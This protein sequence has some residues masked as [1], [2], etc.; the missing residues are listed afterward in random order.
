MCQN[1]TDWESLLSLYN[2]LNILSLCR[3]RFQ[4]NRKFAVFDPIFERSES[5]FGCSVSVFSVSKGIF[6]FWVRIFE[7]SIRFSSF[8]SEVRV[9]LMQ[10]RLRDKAAWENLNSTYTLSRASSLARVEANCNQHAVREF[11]TRD[12]RRAEP[13]KPDRTAACE[14]GT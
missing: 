3:D 1:E 6:D 12:C 10:S 9:A 13:A 5:I 4:P 7:T 14:A 11:E 8:R 2:Q